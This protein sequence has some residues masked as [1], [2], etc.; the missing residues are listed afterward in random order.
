MSKQDSEQKVQ[1]KM[2]VYFV[3]TVEDDYDAVFLVR[4]DEGA[5]YDKGH[6]WG[7]YEAPTRSKAKARFFKE[8]DLEFTT[9]VKTRKLIDCGE[10]GNDGYIE[11]QPNWETGESED[12]TCPE[13]EGHCL[14]D[15]Y[16]R[17]AEPK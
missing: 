7:V 17:W 1:E 13:C 9:P 5:Y 6:L 4:L 16:T 11:G 14:M 3:I 15:D 12:V 2:N 10:C 8:N